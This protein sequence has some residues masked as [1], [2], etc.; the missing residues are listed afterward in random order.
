MLYHLIRS[1]ED[2]GD[3]IWQRLIRHVERDK[4][5]AGIRRLPEVQLRRWLLSIPLHL[6]AYIVSTGGNSIRGN[7]LAFGQACVQEGIPLHEAIRTLHILKHGILEFASEEGMLRNGGDLYAQGQLHSH[8]SRLFDDL[9]YHAVL[10]YEEDLTRLVQAHKGRDSDVWRDDCVELIFDPANTEREVYQ[11]VINPAGVLFD[12]A[13]SNQEKN[14]KCQYSSAV[15]A[16]RGYWAC[17][18]ALDG[19]DLDNHPIKPGTIWSL[20][21]YRTRIGLG[22]EQ[23]S[24]WPTFGFSQRMD[25]FPIAIFK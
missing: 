2:H 12:Q 24:V 15:F 1:I 25:I 10:G 23:T 19:E 17:E 9:V 3:H 4:H 5:L 16:D 18:F 6:D 22:N 7:C 14:F 13:N 21:V 20:N 11:F 8:V